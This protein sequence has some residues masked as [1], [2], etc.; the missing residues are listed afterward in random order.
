[1]I[2]KPDIPWWVSALLMILL[3]YVAIRLSDSQKEVRRLEQQLQPVEYDYRETIPLRIGNKTIYGVI[4]INLKTGQS[5]IS[6]PVAISDLS[7]YANHFESDGHAVVFGS[8][9]KERL[10]R[11][12]RFESLQKKLS[13]ND[14]FLTTKEPQ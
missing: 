6:H 13:E 2:N 7:D 1:M 11:I 14:S 3:S 5:A 10:A 8:V 12:N 9:S 4:N